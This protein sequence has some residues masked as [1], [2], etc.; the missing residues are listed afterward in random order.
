[1]YVSTRR[2]VNGLS[3]DFI[4]NLCTLEYRSSMLYQIHDAVVVLC[5]VRGPNPA[6]TFPPLRVL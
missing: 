2:K 5:C 6:C 4:Q 3:I 1:M